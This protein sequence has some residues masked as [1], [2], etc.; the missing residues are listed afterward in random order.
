MKA[1]LDIVRDVVENGVWKENRTGIRTKTVVNAIFSHDMKNGFPLLTTKKMGLKNIAV[2]L[3][4]F[5]KGITS[6]AWYQERKCHIWDSW[7]NP[8]AVKEELRISKIYNPG[9]SV[10]DPACI[11]IAQ[12]DLDDLGPIYGYQWRRFNQVYDEN[13][14]GCIEKYDQLQNILDTLKNNPDDR[15]MVCIAWNPCQLSIMALPPCHMLWGLVHVN[16]VLSLYWTQR[17]CDLMLGIP[18][19]IA[20]YA[21]LLTLLCKQFNMVPGNL[22]G[23]LADCHIYENQLEGAYKQLDRLPRTL[24]GVYIDGDKSFNILDWTYENIKLL[25]YNPYEKIS[26]GDVAI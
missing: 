13:D 20:S 16:N 26:F 8:K 6:K 17:S 22:T 4:G 9:I 18:Y 5:I 15:R 1:Y 24:P 23:L 10:D 7:A 3:E 11:K 14:N 25:D 21:L 12:Q 2:E 19:N